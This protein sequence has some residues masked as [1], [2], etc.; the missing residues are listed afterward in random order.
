VDVVVATGG[1]EPARVASALDLLG[2][3]GITSVMLEG[4]PHL[5]GAFLDAGEVDEARLFVAPMMLGGRGAR[6][7]VEG[8]GVES[9]ADAVSALSV[10]CEP[11]DDDLLIIVRLR[12]W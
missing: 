3:T 8:E 6:A 10:D 1:N 12:E 4:G 5:A 11:V 7:P 2:A 9:I